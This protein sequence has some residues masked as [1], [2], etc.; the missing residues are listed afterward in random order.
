ME[1]SGVVSFS[2]KYAGCFLLVMVA[3]VYG[4]FSYLVPFQLDDIWYADLY[5]GFNDGSGRFSFGEFCETGLYHWLHQNGRLGNLLCPLFVAVFPKWLTAFFV[6]LCSALLY[7]VSVKLYAGSRRVGITELLLFLLAFAVLL[8]WHDNIMV[9]DFALNYLLSA[10]FNVLFIL[11]FSGMQACRR[12][13]G[14]FFLLASVSVA[15]MAG[16]MHEGVS[17]PV[18]CGLTVLLIR[19]HFKFVAFEWVLAISYAAGAVL[20]AFS[21]G[22]W[23]RI[24][25][26][27]VGGVS[28]SVRHMLRTLALCFPVSGFL[29]AVVCTGCLCKRLRERIG[30]V[31]SSDLFVLLVCIMVS[32]YFIVIFSKASFRAAFFSELLGI[33]LVFRLSVNLIPSFCRRVRIAA[34]GLCI[35]VLCAFYSGVL[36]WQYRIYEQCRYIYVELENRPV[37]FADMVE[38][39]PWYTLGQT[40][41]GLWRNPLQFHVLNEHYG[42]NKQ[43][44]VLPYSLKGFDCDRA[45]ALGGDAGAVVY[46]GYTLIPQNDALA[47]ESQHQPYGEMY[48]NAGFRVKNSDG[49]EY[50]IYSALIGFNDKDGCVWYLLRP[51][52]WYWNDA[53]VSVDFD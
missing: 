11:L 14:K 9:A 19:R 28:F 20:V 53:F 29:T 21:P 4:V 6:G 15:F 30:N 8:P 25:G 39:S 49:R 48:M 51:D 35:V 23:G 38:Y 31:I 52:R 36:F 47:A 10:L 13:A 22:L 45:V 24:D 32:S 2:R 42:A 16:W 3:L 41:D 5:K 26:V 40:T 33:V 18:L 17:L 27:D 43:V 12:V 50:G 37:L 34:C 1:M 44:V 7:C 46:E